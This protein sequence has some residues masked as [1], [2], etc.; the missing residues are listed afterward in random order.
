MTVHSDSGLGFLFALIVLFGALVA[1][2]VSVILLFERKFRSAAR[3]SIT[4]LT[5]MI[6]LPLI[7]GLVAGITPQTI[8]KLGDTYC[9]DIQ[10]IGIENIAKE[11]RGGET[12][13]ALDVRLFS[14]ANTVKVGFG[15]VSFFLQDEQG[16]QF[17]LLEDAATVYDIY[18]EPQQTVKRR[19]TFAVASDAKELFLVT[20]DHAP[21]NASKRCSLGGKQPPFWAPLAGVW[22][23]L[24][25][26]GNDAHPLH[27]PTMMRVV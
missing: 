20:S 5:V 13:Y 25:S 8:V 6:G 18:L 21:A 26:F 27:K 7:V 4:T 1:F 16:R 10:C 11:T 22:F 12:V 2:A 3:V 23:G 14:D 15:C 24:A 17:P 9:A 19:F